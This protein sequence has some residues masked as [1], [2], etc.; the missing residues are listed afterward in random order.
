MRPIRVSLF[1]HS[2]LLS[3]A[4]AERLRAE[5]GFKLVSAR[6][7]TLSALRSRRN[8]ACDVAVLELDLS[9]EEMLESV[10]AIQAQRPKT[11]WILFSPRPSHLLLAQTLVYGFRGFLTEDS[12]LQDL[13]DAVRKVADGGN[14]CCRS[15]CD[16]LRVDES[17]GK[18]R[19]RRPELVPDLSD[20]EMDVLRL[21]AF[22]LQTQQMGDVL[23][24]SGKSIESTKYRLMKRL[25]IHDRVELARF[26][27]KE[28]LVKP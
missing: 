18:L 19:V 27:I 11:Q 9:S 24:R 13:L 4:C 1:L 20:Y 23:E 21:L 12:R 26:A 6:T 25:D 3:D 17:D 8:F 7:P 22:G 10:E 14:Y 16:R 28:G 5:Q 15:L 2:R